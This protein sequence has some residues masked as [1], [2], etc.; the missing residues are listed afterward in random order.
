MN[1]EQKQWWRAVSGKAESE[2]ELRQ[3]SRGG[4]GQ[5]DLCGLVVRAL[6]GFPEAR[7]AVLAALEEAGVAG[8][9]RYL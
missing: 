7:A 5:A 6:A 8:A 3:G 4:R 1:R 9:C 2:S